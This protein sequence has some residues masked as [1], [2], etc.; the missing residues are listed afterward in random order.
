MSPLR[1]KKERRLQKILSGKVKNEAWLIHRQL[2]GAQRV[3]AALAQYEKKPPAY[4]RFFV[5][6]NDDQWSL[7]SLSLVSRTN[8]VPITA[9]PSAMMIGYQR[10]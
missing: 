1:D 10:P 9:V 7:M 5:K 8:R 2:M 3:R 4:R 6:G